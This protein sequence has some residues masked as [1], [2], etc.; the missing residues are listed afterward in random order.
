MTT[1]ERVEFT[2]RQHFANEYHSSYEELVEEAVN[3]CIT[4]STPIGD[5]CCEDY[6]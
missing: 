4:K 5:S 2:I 6:R 3:E 1:E